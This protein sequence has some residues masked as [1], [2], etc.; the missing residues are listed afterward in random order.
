MFVGAKE[1][2]L[3]LES[4]TSYPPKNSPCVLGRLAPKLG[5]L[6]LCHILWFLHRFETI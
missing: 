2:F 5:A 6:G 4:L 3:D 1:G